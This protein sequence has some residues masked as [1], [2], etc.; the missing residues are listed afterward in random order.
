MKLIVQLLTCNNVSVTVFSSV[1]RMLR[2]FTLV[3]QTV[4]NFLHEQQTR[5]IKQSSSDSD[6]QSSIH[7]VIHVSSFT[8]VHSY[9]IDC[10]AGTL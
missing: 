7:T 2:Y 6:N 8:K 3:L 1:I 5:S 9:L 10:I 4:R